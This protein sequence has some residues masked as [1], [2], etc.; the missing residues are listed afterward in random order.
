[1]IS[2]LFGLRKIFNQ[3]GT[4]FFDVSRFNVKKDP[5]HYLRGFLQIVAP[6]F[7][8]LTLA[9]IFAVAN[10]SVVYAEDNG[11]SQP[12]TAEVQTEA[13]PGVLDE[14]DAPDATPSDETIKAEQDADES[15][16]SSDEESIN[17]IIETPDVA[18]DDAPEEAVVESE[19]EVNTQ[20]ALADFA[21]EADSAGGDSEVEVDAE[22]DPL[23]EGLSEDV[24]SETDMGSEA[25]QS[26]E[27]LD[28][29][30]EVSVEIVDH[31]LEVAC[32]E[33]SA[34]G[35]DA[36]GGANEVC[37]VSDDDEIIFDADAEPKGEAVTEAELIV[38]AELPEEEELE[39]ED[40][41]AEPTQTEES[42]TVLDDDVIIPDPYF[43]VGGV[44]HSYLPSGGDCQ[45]Q[46][47]CAV[48]TT[49]IQDAINAISGGLTPDD[50]TIY[51]EGGS[52]G[53]NIALANID[54]DLTIIGSANGSAS[55][56]D[57]AIYIGNSS[58][59]INLQQITFN[60]GLSIILADSVTL[61]DSTLNAGVV[62]I[63]SDLSIDTCT[64]NAGLAAI[65]STVTIMDSMVNA[66][67]ADI[68][69]NVTIIDADDDGDA[70]I[71]A[72]NSTV[73]AENTDF[74][75]GT[76]L[77][78]EN[79]SLEIMG[80]AQDDEIEVALVGSGTSDVIIDGGAGADNII[81]DMNGIDNDVIV[82]DSGASGDDSL[83]INLSGSDDVLLGG[84]Q[85]VAGSETIIFD[86]SI[87]NLS[88][89]A[90]LEEAALVIEDELDV[91]G[92]LDITAATVVIDADITA[93]SVAL[94]AGGDILHTNEATVLTE[95]AG[96]IVYTA[97][98]DRSDATI[99][100][101]GN[102]ISESGAIILNATDD[103]IIGIHAQVITAGE[104]SINADSDGDGA[105]SLVVLGELNST[106]N[107]ISI[108]AADVEITGIVDA[109]SGDITLT[110]SASSI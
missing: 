35:G 81:L 57:G 30:I 89:N 4:V 34:G 54:Y 67:L 15:I 55:I 43:F 72:A 53:E 22:A 58:G 79:S 85:L 32:E 38:G 88:V 91:T 98:L 23:G 1:M 27:S 66:G 87:E 26:Y 31:S 44:K 10:V 60:A 73:R 51:I 86:Q 68:N 41:V 50:D 13:I 94:N 39:V 14:E 37:L 105:G 108:R 96:A 74:D 20:P 11:P 90:D 110:P 5:N 17:I 45:G 6:Q 80:T 28:L 12:P 2:A 109:G 36:Q 76:V 103:V 83:R 100:I 59:N 104:L 56:L 7:I 78:V 64:M 84:T 18:N 99:T 77:Q 75:D 92:Q 101:L 21:H 107:L 3:K 49:P 25:S 46:A 19:V 63:N 93:G 71:A 40:A 8:A 102:L 82:T 9:F 47:N 97:G 65:S 42:S 70:D 48:S 29:S 106:N 52:Y 61:Q 33:F 16:Q 24:V 69:S 95:G 62:A